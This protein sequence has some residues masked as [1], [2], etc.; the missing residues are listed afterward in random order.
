MSSKRVLKTPYPWFGGKKTVAETVW[1]RFGDVAN[2]VEPFFGG[3]AMLLNRPVWHTG[4]TE[5]VNDINAWL[6]NFWRAVKADPDAVAHYA[7]DPVNELD[8]HSRGDWLFYRRDYAD[9]V[10]A[11]RS[12]PEYYDTKSAGWWVWGQCAWIGTGWGR[13]ESRDMVNRKRPELLVNKGVNRKLPHLGDA[14]MGVNRKLPHLGDAGMGDGIT[15]TSRKAAITQYMREL[16]ARFAS[17]RVC[18]GDWKRVCT[19]DATTV[20]HGLTGVFLDPPYA[21]DDRANCYDDNDT[22]DLAHE[23]RDWAIQN[24]DRMRIALCGYEEHDA[25]MPDTWECYR[26]KAAGGYASHG[27]EKNE[28]CKRETIWFSPMCLKP[29]KR[30]GFF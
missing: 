23:V 30:V 14:G 28:N 27:S 5:T 29:N 26:W 10:E 22:F 13:M 2:S 4:H 17:V 6:T 19:S 9:F 24:G 12:D 1:E 21:V 25:F 11:M 3:G 18:C 20:K 7:S 8:L 16:A 15:D